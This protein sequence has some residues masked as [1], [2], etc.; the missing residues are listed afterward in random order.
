LTLPDKWHE[1]HSIFIFQPLPLSN[2]DDHTIRKIR[3]GK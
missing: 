2:D 3:K 1:G